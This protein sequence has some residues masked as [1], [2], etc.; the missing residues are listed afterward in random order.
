MY[1][2]G[3]GG[4]A[5]RVKILIDAGADVNAVNEEGMTALMYASGREGDAKRVKILIDA[6]ADTNATTENGV[7]AL[8]YAAQ[9]KKEVCLLLICN[10]ARVD[11]RDC[12]GSTALLKCAK[13]ADY[14]SET[15]EALINAGA[16]VNI[17]DRSGDSPLIVAARSRSR[18]MKG[19]KLLIEAGACMNH[20]NSRG[21]T[22]L[23][24]AIRTNCYIGC[25]KMLLDAD[26]DVNL[27]KNDGNTPLMRCARFLDA[28]TVDLLLQ[29]G[30][31]INA[32]QRNGWTALMFASRYGDPE[33]VG[34]LINKG[35]F[36]HERNNNLETAIDIARSCGKQEI[37]RI[38]ENPS[39]YT[40]EAEKSPRDTD[41]D[42]P[43]KGR[44]SLDVAPHIEAS[45][46]FL[47]I[48]YRQINFQEVLGSGSFGTVSRAKWNGVNVA[49][50]KFEVQNS[51][52]NHIMQQEFEN[53]VL[54]EG[55]ML[56][57]LTHPYIVACYGYCSKPPCLV[58]ELCPRGNLS[59]V[60]SKCLEDV[61]QGNQ[62][63][64]RKRL[65]MAIQ[66]AQALKFLHNH[67]RQGGVLHRDLRTMNI[68]VT[69]DWTA[70][71]TDLGMSR[72]ADQVSTR[73][74]GT[75]GGNNP[76]WMPPEVL[77]SRPFTRSGESYCFG[78]ILWEMMMWKHPWE[79]RTNVEV[80]FER[81][82]LADLS[83]PP[84]EE[85]D[86]LPGP[87]PSNRDTIST[88]ANLTSQCLHHEPSS[89][90]DL[91]HIIVT[92]ER[93]KTREQDPVHPREEPK[94]CV[95]IERRPNIIMHPCGHLCLC[96]NCALDIDRCPICRA[97]GGP[98]QVYT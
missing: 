36:I 72:F 16:D 94:C 35:A 73:S 32:K 33:R 62:M 15:C 82:S 71:I 43:E 89:R 4:D 6:G 39:G 90:P 47:M 64:W 25:I 19:I 96:E 29:R 98:H 77:R 34:L 59:E 68:V 63:T 12:D 95:C 66:V 13:L 93:L 38:L 40:A 55:E 70:K 30:A 11:E 1:A 28:D 37:V 23:L 83:V 74:A 22:A 8:M 26:A 54:P 67:P 97:D 75:L 57:T 41:D 14:R 92:L 10:G 3:R 53:Y 17:S 45:T 78:I 20:Q 56:R 85:W 49:V 60:L 48:D 50:K 51:C 24:E 79:G 69:H 87:N 88:F 58:L 84:E 76:R 46:S 5:R 81:L 21:W 80:M 65:E 31:E 91:E 18:N 44:S 2:S 52:L 27:A 86:H 7:T 9:C 42:S 61:D